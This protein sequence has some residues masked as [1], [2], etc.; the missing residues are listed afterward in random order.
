MS[1]IEQPDLASPLVDVHDA[2]RS[3]GV[4]FEELSAA[5]VPD[6]GEALD[7][8]LAFVDEYRRFTGKFTERQLEYR[9]Q[10]VEWADAARAAYL[11]RQ[12]DRLVAVTASF[13]FQPGRMH[14]DWK[15]DFEAAGEQADNLLGAAIVKLYADERRTLIEMLQRFDRHYAAEKQKLGVL[16][17]SDLE[18][19]AIRLLE[20]HP[21][22]RDRVQMQFRQILMD[23]YQDTNG[24]QARL[25]QLLRGRGNFYAVGDINQSIFGFRHATPGV[26]RRHR[27]RVRTAGEH[28]VELFDNFRSRADI[29]CAVEAVVEDATGVESH[30]LNACRDLPLK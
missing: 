2:V 3:A 6:I 30:Q 21:A 11:A 9:D 13:K 17:F 28:H 29:L 20:E 14:R 22:V 8:I 5:E 27:D 18:H 4:S 16:D 12:W 10:L 15:A 24:Q 1:A 23:E 26:F 25:L 19:F 7:A